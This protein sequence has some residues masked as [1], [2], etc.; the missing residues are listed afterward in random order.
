MLKQG[1]RAPVYKGGRKDPLIVDSYR[2]VTLT[3]MVAKVLELFFFNFLG[4]AATGLHVS[5]HTPCEPISL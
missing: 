1:L 4:M 2:G 5:R 3:S